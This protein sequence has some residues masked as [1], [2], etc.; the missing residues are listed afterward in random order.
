MP[1]RHWCPRD[2]EAPV[3]WWCLTT[4]VPASSRSL[5]FHIERVGTLSDFRNDHPD[6]AYEVATGLESI[7]FLGTPGTS[8][9]AT[10]TTTNSP[11][12]ATNVGV[13]LN[14]APASRD[15]IRTPHLTEDQMRKAFSIIPNDYWQLNCWTCRECGHSTFTCPTLTPTQRMYFAYQYYLDQVRTNPSTETFLAEKTQRRIDVARER[16]EGT[17]TRTD[18]RSNVMHDR[19]TPTTH[20]K[21]ILTNPH[22]RF[23]RPPQRKANG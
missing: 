10:P 21:S 2:L 22:P 13:Y 14:E 5:V 16:R 15:T 17:R 11:E 9:A 7:L 8:T 18:Q 20:P 6:Y 4:T 1:L 12:I 3:A 19:I 23:E